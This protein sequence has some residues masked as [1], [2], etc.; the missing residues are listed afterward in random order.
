MTTAIAAMTA[1]TYI[2]PLRRPHTVL[3]VC[4]ALGEDFGFN[5]LWLR[6]A[7]AAGLFFNTAL[8]FGL[9]FGLGALVALSRWIAPVGQASAAPLPA[10]AMATDNDSEEYRIA[11]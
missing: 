4:E 9:Y 10:A 7:F 5:P 11:A 8:A 1:P 3:G 2:S 6:I